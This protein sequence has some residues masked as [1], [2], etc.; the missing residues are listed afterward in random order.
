MLK[1][2]L[3]IIAAASLSLFLAASIAPTSSAYA[4]VPGASGK[5]KSDLEL[6][7]SFLQR[8]PDV[9]AEMQRDENEFRQKLRQ[10]PAAQRPAMMREFNEERNAD[11]M[12]FANQEKRHSEVQSLKAE[13]NY[14]NAL[15]GQEPAGEDEAK[16]LALQCGPRENVGYSNYFGNPSFYRDV[17]PLIGKE[18]ADIEAIPV[19]R[20]KVLPTIDADLR[21]F[22]SNKQLTFKGQNFNTKT[23][24]LHA[25]VHERGGQREF[26]STVYQASTQHNSRRNQMLSDT[27]IKDIYDALDDVEFPNPNRKAGSVRDW[28][29]EK[30]TGR[31][32]LTECRYFWA[33]NNTV[34]YEDP[35]NTRGFVMPG[36]RSARSGIKPHYKL[37]EPVQ[38]RGVPVARTDLNAGKFEAQAKRSDVSERMG[39][40]EKRLG[41]KIKDR[42]AMDV[43]QQNFGGVADAYEDF[44]TT[45][46]V[47][48]LGGRGAFDPDSASDN[49]LGNDLRGS[50]YDQY[51]SEEGSTNRQGFDFDDLYQ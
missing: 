48:R 15:G 5:P 9:A 20:Y 10:A 7:N 13:K 44:E 2:H 4:D 1:N 19:L 8:N 40:Y 50:A 27:M 39:K 18:M 23:L 47:R 29:N 45:T 14:K 41:P 12:R 49:P 11:I 25:G 46:N 42:T 32:V 16:R 26:A 38:K 28:I 33:N 17:Y 37:A 31:D 24:N 3:S 36:N 21:T 51:D 6:A 22:I 34:R 30:Y 43:V 35:N